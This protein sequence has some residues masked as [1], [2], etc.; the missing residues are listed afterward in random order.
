MVLVIRCLGEPDCLD[1]GDQSELLVVRTITTI[2]Q[3][4]VYPPRAENPLN[5]EGPGL[6][7]LPSLLPK[8]DANYLIDRGGR[9]DLFR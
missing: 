9:I 6:D 4:V 3:E 5:G 8:V 2:N 1:L 7:V